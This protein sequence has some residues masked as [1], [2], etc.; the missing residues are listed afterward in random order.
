MNGGEQTWGLKDT[1]REPGEALELLVLGSGDVA[2]K[3]CVD[4][5]TSLDTSLYFPWRVDSPSS[6]LYQWKK[7]N[8]Q[9]KDS[10]RGTVI[11]AVLPIPQT[12]SDRLHAQRIGT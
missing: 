12:P 1:D 11:A 3:L 2:R 8:L 9:N 4:F 7:P 10:S 6:S 5:F